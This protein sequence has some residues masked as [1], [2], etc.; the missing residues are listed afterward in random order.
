MKFLFK[1]FLLAALVYGGW[2][3]WKNYDFPGWYE[4]ARSAIKIG[5]TRQAIVLPRKHGEQFEK[6][7]IIYVKNN[8]EF[9]PEKVEIL[10]G[11]TIAWYNETNKEQM[12]FIEN[13]DVKFLRPKI[14]FYKTYASPGTFGFS[15]DDDQNFNGQVIVK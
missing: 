11:Q 15:C 13:F 8:C 9:S 3:L 2:W 1:L 12:L 6:Q 7:I 10:A 5:N 4:H 14:F